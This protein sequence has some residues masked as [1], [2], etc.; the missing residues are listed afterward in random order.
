MNDS[1]SAGTDCSITLDDGTANWQRMLGPAGLAND[2][3]AR[4]M[5]QVKLS[6]AGDYRYTIDATGSLTFDI[7]S[8]RYLAVRV[9]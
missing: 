8:F 6:S 7:P 9:R 3:K 4:G 5:A 2:M 1:G